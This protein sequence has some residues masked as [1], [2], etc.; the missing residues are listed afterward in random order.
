MLARD[1]ARRLASFDG[2]VRILVAG[3][4]RTAQEFIAQWDVLGHR[5]DSRIATC[6]QASHSFVE[7][8]SRDW[9]LA[10]LTEML[11]R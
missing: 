5:R 4:D 10:Q 2:P 3:R 8:E 9:L 6:P 7:P 1:M 11:A